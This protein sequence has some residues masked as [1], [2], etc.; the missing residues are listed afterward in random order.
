MIGKAYRDEKLD[1]VYRVAGV[2]TL[3][4]EIIGGESMSAA[5]VVHAADHRA[6]LVSSFEASRI[7]D[8]LLVSIEVVIRSGSF[9][10]PVGKEFVI[11][12]VA[13]WKNGKLWATPR[14]E[15]LREFEPF[16]VGSGDLA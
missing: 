4:R 3:D 7:A 12:R 2:L 15:F 13:D 1:R 6:E 9:R 5:L 11:Y 8:D 14:N 10:Y 16:D